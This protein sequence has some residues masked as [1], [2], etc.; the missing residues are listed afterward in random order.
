MKRLLMLAVV[1]FVACR[2]SAL[3]FVCETD[4]QCSGGQCIN[5]LCAFPDPTCPAGYRYKGA[6]ASTGMCVASIIPLPGDMASRA[7]LGSGDMGLVDMSAHAPIDG[8]ACD[9]TRPIDLGPAA[10]LSWT[11]EDSTTTWRGVWGS[12]AA[13]VYAVGNAGKVGHRTASGTW[14]Y[15][16]SIATSNNL[17]S[18]WGAGPSDIYV[19]G[20]ALSTSGTQVTVSFFNGGTWTDGSATLGGRVTFIGINKFLQLAYRQDTSGFHDIGSGGGMWAAG[21]PPPPTEGITAGWGTD[22]DH[23]RLASGNA[24][25][26][27]TDG[28]TFAAEASGLGGIINVIWGAT[29]TDLYLCGTRQGI[30]YSRGDG[31][32]TVQ[33]ENASGSTCR[34][35]WSSSASDIYAVGDAGLVLHSTGNGKWDSITIPGVTTQNFYGVWG[36]GANDVY[37]VGDGAILHG[38]RP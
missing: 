28:S 26:A 35:M 5:H 4:P 34:G 18:V 12:G 17:L 19:A 31:K 22:G 25:Y 37:I 10:G 33:I 27:T 30:S 1:A 3:R 6:G 8:C 7:P 36:S 29:A 9:M 14:L 15:S 11:L 16:A 20:D 23:V 2:T 21:G 38:V 13:N 32:W 24:V